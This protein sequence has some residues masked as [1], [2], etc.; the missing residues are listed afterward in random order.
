MF[1]P[2]PSP[3]RPPLQPDALPMDE[4]D[5]SESEFGQDAEEGRTIETAILLTMSH[6]ELEQQRKKG[7]GRRIRWIVVLVPAILILIALSTHIASSCS[8]FS[9][10]HAFQSLERQHHRNVSSGHFHKRSPIPQTQPQGLTLSN[11]ASV[12]G[13]QL[14]TNPS[15]SSNSPTSTNPV[16]QTSQTIPPAPPASAPA[17]L[18]TPFPQPFDSVGATTNLSTSSCQAFFQ[19]MTQADDFRKCRPLG[20]LLQFGSDFIEVSLDLYFS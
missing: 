13:S 17:V 20:L 14:S 6:A 16:P 19:N 10:R 2:P 7:V 5:F 4:K 11:T 1:T 18:P 15:G 12:T 3:F 8:P 9:T